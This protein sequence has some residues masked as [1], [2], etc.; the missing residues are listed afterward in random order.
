[1]LLATCRG[2][3]PERVM[4]PLTGETLPEPTGEPV[5]EGTIVA[6]FSPEGVIPPSGPTVGSLLG[7]TEAILE[8]PPGDCGLT[9]SEGRQ[10][11]FEV[12]AGSPLVAQ[13][14]R[15]FHLVKESDLVALS[16][17][18]ASDPRGLQLVS[19]DGQ[20]AF[21]DSGVAANLVARARKEPAEPGLLADTTRSHTLVFSDAPVYVGP[22][23]FTTPVGAAELVVDAF[24]VDRTLFAAANA[25]K[26]KSHF[27]Q[28]GPGTL[29]GS[30]VQGSDGDWPPCNGCSPAAERMCCMVPWTLHALFFSPLILF[31]I[32]RK[33]LCNKHKDMEFPPW[34]DAA[35][36]L[37]DKGII[38]RRH[39][40]PDSSAEQLAPMTCKC[41]F[42]CGPTCEQEGTGGGGAY[43]NVMRQPSI[44]VVNAIAWSGFD[45]DKIRIRTYD[46]SSRCVTPGDP[47]MAWDPLVVGPYFACC[48]PMATCCRCIC[49]QPKVDRLYRATIFSEHS[50]TYHDSDGGGMDIKT[51]SIELLALAR[52]PDDLRNTLRAAKEKY[53]APAAAAMER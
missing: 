27:C 48:V 22:G 13:I 49:I 46:A 42:C 44:N 50:T 16:P 45:V 12:A 10:K 2:K 15:G 14:P 30:E 8:L 47:R 53:G 28:G 7:I 34:G 9:V 32:L 31:D 39:F 43:W 40:G 20:L 36:V 29:Q 35:L 18:A 41:C 5:V 37:T 26:A 11:T 38:G 1:L 52:S 6:E 4:E 33:T 3:L 51:G 17:G 23:G 19:V 24:A 21:P 25:A